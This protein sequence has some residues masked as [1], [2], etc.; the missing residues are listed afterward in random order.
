MPIPNQRLE[1]C[2]CAAA[3]MGK[4]SPILASKIR[5]HIDPGFSHDDQNIVDIELG[6]SPQTPKRVDSGVSFCNSPLD[7]QDQTKSI[8]PKDLQHHEPIYMTFDFGDGTLVKPLDYETFGRWDAIDNLTKDLENDGFMFANLWDKVEDMRVDGGDWDA[9]VRP[10]WTINA[11]LRAPVRNNGFE[12]DVDSNSE[13]CEST[14]EEEWRNEYIDEY[15]TDEMEDWCLPRW[16]SKVEQE[17]KEERNQEPSWRVLILGF[18]SVV[19]FMVAVI[20]Y[21]A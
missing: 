17:M 6:E 3:I 7:S 11:S 20:V 19:F 1:P 4:W 16:R 8:P 9:R 18:A 5:R 12:E 14:D 10:G 13:D 15:L 2:M 21:T